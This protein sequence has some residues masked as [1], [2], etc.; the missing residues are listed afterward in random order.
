MYKPDFKEGKEIYI[1]ISFIRQSIETI[2]HTPLDQDNLEAK[3]PKIPQITA[4]ITNSNKATSSI[5][6]RV[7]VAPK[8]FVQNGSFASGNLYNRTVLPIIIQ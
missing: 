8:T 1:Y 3:S 2:P 7:Q 6:D 4:F 5:R